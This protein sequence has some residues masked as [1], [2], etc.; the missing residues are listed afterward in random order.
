MQGK[1]VTGEQIREAVRKRSGV[2]A[3]LA[4]DSQ[5]KPALV[6]RL[7]VSRSTADRAIDELIDAGLAERDGGVY[8]ATNAGK[9]ALDVHRE[10][11]SLTDGIGTAMPMIEA[12]S[13][14]APFDTT[15]LADGAVQL[16]EPHA[17]ENA[18]R[19]TAESL[20]EAE[21]VRGL[22]P[23]IKSSYASLLY[24]QV[25]ERNLEV[26]LI[27]ERDARESLTAVADNRAELANL[28]AADEVQVLE[29]GADL[30]YALW[31]MSGPDI[32][33]TGITVH[34]S[35][36]IVGV[37]T[38]DS[39]DAVEWCRSRYESVREDADPFPVDSLGR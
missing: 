29:T 26:E 37:I 16:A 39:A 17:P 6:E 13:P 33:R 3:E 2:L 18:L 28:L 23:V 32:D 7:D 11:A 36:G 30:P 22:A 35:G 19:E 12:K 25:Q 4:D 38:N 24:E 20:R 21:V 15:L 1:D 31:L 8:R 9:L 27:V 14:D 10:Y 5:R 34:D